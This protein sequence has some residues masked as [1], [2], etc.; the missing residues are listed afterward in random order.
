MGREEQAL[1]RMHER[2]KDQI[3][4]G[5]S[6]LY[7]G[8]GRWWKGSF[9]PQASINH[10]WNSPNTI[11]SKYIAGLRPTRPGWAEFEVLPKEA[12]LLRMEVN[13]QTVKGEISV[14]ISKNSEMYEL[15]VKVPNGSEASL[16]IPKKSFLRIDE[17]SRQPSHE[18]DEFLFFRVGPG[19]A[20]VW[21]KGE[22]IVSSPKSAA[23]PRH[24]VE[25]YDRKD[26]KAFA[27]QTYPLPYPYWDRPQ[28]K[29]E[30]SSP[31]DALNGDLHTFWSTGA[32]QKGGE[33]FVVDMGMSQS[34]SRIELENSWAPY[35]Y[36]RGYKVFVSQDGESWGDPVAVGAGTQSVTR[37]E[38]PV[39]SIRFIRI[40]QTAHESKYWWSISD[41]R[42]Y[43]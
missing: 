4:S 34:V 9:N 42:I 23:Q 10:G 24:G 38:V 14:S 25:P 17:I 13:I 26:M 11:L 28:F 2:Y 32:P 39:R 33:W 19:S 6:T 3:E 41:L 37:I 22:L 16:G 18:N 35:D 7:E 36:P 8:F 31:M 5:F 40:E 12:F 30:G 20:R 29:K 15:R 21:A 1:L 43:A 27:S